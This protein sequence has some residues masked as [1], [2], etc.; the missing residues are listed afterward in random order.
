MPQPPCQR[1]QDREVGGALK[2]EN[3]A[4]LR[5]L[6]VLVKSDLRQR[7]PDL[8]APAAETVGLAD[9]RDYEVPVRGLVEQHFGMTRRDDLAALL[10]RHS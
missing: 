6:V 9:K 5:G 10:V 3:P 4:G 1:L 2:V 7:L 8:A